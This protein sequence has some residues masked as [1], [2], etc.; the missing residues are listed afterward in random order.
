[1]G[2][3]GGI[4][5]NGMNW[6]E[7]K[8]LSQQITINNQDDRKLLAAFTPKVDYDRER[9]SVSEVLRVGRNQ[10]G[11]LLGRMTNEDIAEHSRMQPGYVRKI[12]N[13]EA[14]PTAKEFEHLAK[15]LSVPKVLSDEILTTY[16]ESPKALVT[17]VTNH[18]MLNALDKLKTKHGKEGVSGRQ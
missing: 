17:G 7:F 18:Q 1:M 3:R 13:G 12:M 8:Q 15:L 16:R 11:D 10:K 4:E 5:D 6:E 9:L 14:I 2:G